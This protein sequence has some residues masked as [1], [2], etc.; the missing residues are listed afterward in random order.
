[1]AFD[2]AVGY[3]NLPNGVFSPVIFSQMAQLQFRKKSVVEDITNSDYFGEIASFGDSVKIILEPSITVK[4]YKRGTQVTPQDLEDQDFTLVVDQ[5]NYFA[6]KVDDIEVQQSHVNW[7]EMATNRA[8]YEVRDVY[9]REVLAYMSGWQYDST[10]GLWTA[11]TAPSGTNADSTAGVDELRAD[12]K[13]DAAAFGGAAGNSI[14]VGVTG[15]LGSDYAATPLMI[16]NRINRM[17][18]RKNVP[19]E[20]RWVV[21]DP[22]FKEKLLDENSKLV[23]TDYNKG[24]GEGLLNGRLTSGTIRGL[25]VY[26]SNNLPSIGT[27]P[28]TINKTAQSTNYG[29]LIAGHDSA[30]ATA[31]QINKTEKMRDPDGFADVVRG[32]QLYGRKILRPEA[33][34]TVRYNIAHA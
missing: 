31:T 15:T 26:E 33:L 16:L 9:D 13:L 6:F 1:M 7:M 20:G 22:V 29:I 19:T 11:R 21:I 4:P 30:V 3:S 17:F 12:M 24:E 14:P 18:D 28:E 10:T 2:T 27:G 32:L 8:A 25:R 23:Q 5:A 34:V